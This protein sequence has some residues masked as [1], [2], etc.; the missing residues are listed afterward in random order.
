[1]PSWDPHVRL[2]YVFVPRRFP[3]RIVS[4]D[5][6]RTTDAHHASDHLPVAAELVVAD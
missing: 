2:D 4:C 5:V 1:M 3:G 6:V